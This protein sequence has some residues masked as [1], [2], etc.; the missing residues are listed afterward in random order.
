LRWNKVN[1]IDCV[2]GLSQIEDNSVDCFIID[3]PYNIG[4]DFG[5]NKTRKDIQEYVEWC[6]S[7]LIH[8]ERALK[9]SGTIYIY[10]FSEVLAHI[11]TKLTLPY[12]WLVWHYTNKTT[13]SLQFWQRSHESILCVWKNKE[14]RVFN[15]DAV[16]EPY[17]EN[18][19]KGYSSGKVKR[20]SG[21]GRFN[22]KGKDIETTYKVN[23]KGALPRDVIKVPSLA[24]GSGMAERYVYS[25]SAGKLYTNKQAKI[26][27]IEDG[28]K[29]PTQK[30]TK[31][32]QKL[33]DACIQSSDNKVVIPFAGTG[34]EAYVCEQNNLNWIAFEINE[35]YC[36]M[37]NLLI[38]KG[39]PTNGEKK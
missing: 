12:R 1:L 18:Y 32:T 5:N 9:P 17:T 23:K 4:K 35:D 36:K 39:F 21:T 30:P 3:P 11:S 28:I 15:R 10:G 7:W 24:G 19:I 37:S 20:P 33:L 2:D 29:H 22:T 38:E 27:N 16:R 14:N 6:E 26:L 8:C 25:P 34:S 13:P 31:L